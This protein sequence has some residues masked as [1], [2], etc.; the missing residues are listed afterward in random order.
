D[1]L[2]ISHLAAYNLRIQFRKKQRLAFR[3]LIS[4]RRTSKFLTSPRSPRI[5]RSHGNTLQS[6]SKPPSAR[7]RLQN[8][9][10]FIRQGNFSV[11][12]MTVGVD[13]ELAT[14]LF[15]CNIC[16]KPSLTDVRRLDREVPT[17]QTC[18]SNARVRAVIQ[19]LS[20]ALFPENLLLPDFPTRREIRGLG[21]TDW[22]G[23]ADRLVEKFDYQNTYY[24]TE[25]RL[26]I[27]A[28]SIAPKFM[29]NDFII[30]SDV[31]EHVVPP[32]SRAFENVYKMLNPGG[33]FVLTV[34]YGTQ[35]ETIEHFPELNEFSV[36]EKDGSFV[37]R[38]KT[39]A[40]VVEE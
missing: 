23:Y 33:V 1:R 17:C 38:N 21:M 35:R 13:R 20:T 19:V 11:A 25:P 40:G 28:A 24:H 2:A 12:I 14:L 27:A 7:S 26:D 36:V 37:L 34:P 18:N 6:R 9:R 22:E 30:S 15:C 10:H 31:F 3:H 4:N 5:F 16:G 32:V 8:W 39:R 29:G